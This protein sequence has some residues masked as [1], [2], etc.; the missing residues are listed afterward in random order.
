MIGEQVYR[1][2]E[3]ESTN[4]YA[5]SILSD[6]V[7]GTVVY[8]ESQS[9]GKGR[10]G[11]VWYSPRGGL[12]ISVI[13]KTKKPELIP[14]MAGIGICETLNRYDILTGIKW[15]NDIMLNN[16]KIAGV[17]TEIIDDKIILGIG[18]N[19]NIVDFPEELKEQ[20]SSVLLET[21]KHLDQIT[22]FQ[23]LCSELNRFYNLLESARITE[24]LLMWYHYTIMLGKNVVIELPDKSMQGRVIDIDQDGALILMLPGGKIE[25][26]VA[27]NCRIIK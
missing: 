7:N 11:K 19:L 14:I 24:L 12:Y 22:V 13:L 16:K 1:L 10:F 2:E 18:L 20:A 15:P 27:G 5:K 3:I 17:L 25:R 26:A 4:E 9:A 23:G 8:A 21:K 6:A